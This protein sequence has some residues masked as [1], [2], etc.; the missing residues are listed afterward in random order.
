M[1]REAVTPSLLADGSRETRHKV[2]LVVSLLYP[3]LAA[4]A[5]GSDVGSLAA[6]RAWDPDRGGDRFALADY[7]GFHRDVVRVREALF[8]GD[9]DT[10]LTD[11]EIDVSAGSCAPPADAE[12]LKPP[13]TAYAR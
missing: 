8:A 13:L 12:A 2:R 3:G 1:G 11:A 6:I 10:D 4:M 5:D 7:F 9:D